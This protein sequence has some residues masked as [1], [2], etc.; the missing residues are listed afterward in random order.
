MKGTWRVLGLCALVLLACVVSVGC[1]SKPVAVGDYRISGPYTHSNLAVFLLHGRDKLAGKK[2]LTLDEALK[3]KRLVMY[4]TEN[5]EK[6][7]IENKSQD[8]YVY[9][10][11][12]EI[13]K[14]GKQ[15][16]TLENDYIV[17][18][19]S[20][21]LPIA[22]FCVESGRW[23]ARG[24]ESALIFNAGLNVNLGRSRSVIQGL[25]YQA[26]VW[27]EV[28]RV[29][30]KLRSNTGVALLSAKSPTSMQLTLEH[31]KLKEIL[32]GYTDALSKVVEGKDDVVGFGLAVNGQVVS[33]DAYGTQALFA[34]LWPKMLNAGAQEALT[35]LQ[36]G[37]KFKT[38][39]AGAVGALML[40][41]RNVKLRE[42]KLVAGRKAL[43][44]ESDGVLLFKVQ[45]EDPTLSQI[46]EA[47]VR[48]PKLPKLKELPFRRS[49]GD[50]DDDDDD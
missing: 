12:G 17:P 22:S 48:K 7:E 34:K 13:V 35:E 45:G 6:L 44:W 21:R 2:I 25:R 24:G 36:K 14:G 46:H 18:P 49:D 3:Q 16:R 11:C 8:E 5:V 31:K 47:Y 1:A 26:P 29:Q 4:E 38:P 28:S 33:V 15:D 40:A 39:S 27:K 10:Q 23:S 20:G 43:L 50:D 42:H 41:G 19:H 30:S 37:K 32:K 9:I